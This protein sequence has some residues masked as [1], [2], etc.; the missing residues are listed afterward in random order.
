MD[1]SI[2][3]LSPRQAEAIVQRYYHRRGLGIN[4]ASALSISMNRL[5]QELADDLGLEQDQFAVAT[6]VRNPMVRF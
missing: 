5:I 2:L 6:K 3:T 4:T 1:K